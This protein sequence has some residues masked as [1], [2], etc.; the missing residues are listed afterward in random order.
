[1][2]ILLAFVAPFGN[3]CAEI[4]S[5]GLQALFSFTGPVAGAI[6]CGLLP[7]LIIT[8]MHMAMA[9][10][11]LQNFNY[12]GYDFLLPLFF[13]S[14]IAVAGATLGA[15]FK[16]KK[17]S[18]KSQSISVGFLAIL[19]ITEPALYGVDIRYKKPLYASFIGGAV[20]GAIAM[21]LATKSYAYVMPGIF[22]LPTYFDQS[23]NIVMILISIAAA[24]MAS[25]AASILMTKDS[26]GSFE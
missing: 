3:Y 13:I 12:L 25:F 6:F 16:I 7:L 1:M 2:P 11:I 17:K 5:K 4:L 20:G 15:S 22:S 9:P 24:F 23:N 21:L 8:G 18:I 26:D 10:L 14:N 19:G